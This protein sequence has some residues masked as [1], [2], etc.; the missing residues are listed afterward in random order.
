MTRARATPALL[1]ALLALAGAS[2]AW[3]QVRWSRQRCTKAYVAWYDSHFNPSRAL[4]PSQ[5]S[6]AH[7]YVKALERAHHCRVGP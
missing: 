5:V 4:T 6:Q 3:A 7:A 1:L 2:P